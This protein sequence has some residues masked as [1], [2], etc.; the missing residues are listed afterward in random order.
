MQSAAPEI[1][2]IKSAMKASWSA[3]DFGQIAQYAAK[4]VEQFVSR[5]GIRPGM[6]V[7]DVACGT[8]NLSIP[9]A[10]L[11]AKVTGVDIAPNLLQ[12][13]RLRDDRDVRRVAALDPDRQ[14]GL[15]VVRALVLDLDAG[16]LAELR[17]G[18]LILG[19]CQSQE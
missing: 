9:A 5:I 15:E 7:L 12:Q 13:A 14:L 8:G 6:K 11:G 1:A 4:G 19:I 10:R 16:T 17:P 18:L 3:G 2:Q